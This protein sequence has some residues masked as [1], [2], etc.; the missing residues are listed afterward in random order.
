MLAIYLIFVND[1]IGYPVSWAFYDTRLITPACHSC[2][3][4]K[5]SSNESELR[6]RSRRVHGGLGHSYN[7]TT[8]RFD[9]ILLLIKL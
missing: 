7:F 5:L 3:G 2:I 4:K 1:F 8:I 6:F 9:K